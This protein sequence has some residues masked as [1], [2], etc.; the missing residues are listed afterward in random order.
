MTALDA[1]DFTSALQNADA[2]L[3]SEPDN[4]VALLNKATALEQQGSLQFKEKE[5]GTQAIAL[6]QQALAIN[7]KSSDAWRIIGYAYE[8]MQRYPE[9]H[10]AYSKS[11]ALNP[12]NAATISQDAHAYDLEGD[13]TRAESGY[14][15]ALQIDPNLDHARMGLARMLVARG[16]LD[17]ALAQ[18]KLVMQ[19][20]SNARQ[21][22]EAAYSAGVIQNAQK[23]TAEA[24]VL[25]R[26][27]IDLDPS[28]AQGWGGLGEVLFAESVNQAKIGS[29]TGLAKLVDESLAAFGKSI[30]LNPNLAN[31][32]LQ[33]A[34][35][36]VALGDDQRALT[37]INETI[38][39]IPNDITL[40]A[41]SKQI[42]AKQATALLVFINSQKGK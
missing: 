28:Y 6:A 12:A 10:D 1:N 35:S 41:P 2:A 17:D 26:Q 20:S 11:L 22:A 34:L 14:T 21:K 18:Y 7:S 42:L 36:M 13:Y 25:M 29:D 24:E 9:A 16:K 15:Q 31:A 32:Q 30:A 19:S 8:I 3:A 23:K 40:S 39:T 38:K 4:V 37:V 5:L 33:L 27:A